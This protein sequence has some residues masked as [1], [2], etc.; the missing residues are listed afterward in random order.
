MNIYEEAIKQADNKALYLYGLIHEQVQRQFI[1]S[2][3]LYITLIVSSLV[4]LILSISIIFISTANSFLHTFSLIGIP[5]GMLALLVAMLRNPITQHRHLLD[6]T[7]KLNI[8]FLS[9]VRRTQQSDLMLQ[10]LFYESDPLELSKMY[11]LIQDFQNI[12][13]Q[14]LEEVDQITSR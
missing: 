5:V 13:D 7:L 14:T 6:T 11:S 3:I 12:V 4:I 2:V 10:S 1:L 9:F 8:V